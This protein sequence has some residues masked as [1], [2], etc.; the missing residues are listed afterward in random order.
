MEREA[1]KNRKDAEAYK[2]AHKSM[3]RPK[4]SNDGV[5]FFFAAQEAQRWIPKPLKK[6]EI[7]P[8][9]AKSFKNRPRSGEESPKAPQ[10][11]PRLPQE[12]PSPQG[13]SGHQLAVVAYR[14]GQPYC[15]CTKP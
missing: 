4:L 5:L 10:E 15:M 11:Q 13:G 12:P 7:A 9:E 1:R 14:D 2:I 6:Q 3:E 8:S